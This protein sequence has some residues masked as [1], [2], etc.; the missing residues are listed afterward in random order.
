MIIGVFLCLSSLM[1]QLLVEVLRLKKLR[2]DVVSEKRFP[3]IK[4]KINKAILR[5]KIKKGRFSSLIDSKG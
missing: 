4:R 2:K 3:K 1:F 5:K